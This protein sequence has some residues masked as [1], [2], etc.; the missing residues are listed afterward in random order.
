MNVRS[1]RY[2]S[3]IPRRDSGWSERT[4]HRGRCWLRPTG[5][6][7]A[8]AVAVAWP[9]EG[10]LGP[11]RRTE[12]GRGPFPTVRRC[13]TR[14]P[15]RASPSPP[16]ALRRS[17]N[18]SASM[19]SARARRQAATATCRASTVCS[20][21][22]AWRPAPTTEVDASGARQLLDDSPVESCELGG[23]LVRQQD[24]LLRAQAVLQRILRR[25]RPAFGRLRPARPRA[26]LAA[27]LNA[28]MA[29]LDG[30]ARDR[31]GTRHGIDPCLEGGWLEGWPR[32]SRQAA[33]RFCC[34]R[35][36]QSQGARASSLAG[37]S[38]GRPLRPPA[39]WPAPPRQCSR[40]GSG[41][42]HARPPHPPGR[43]RRLTSVP[44]RRPSRRPSRPTASRL[45]ALARGGLW[46]WAAG[47]AGA[48]PAAAG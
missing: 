19:R 27:R 3:A 46:A 34:R 47:P 31:A 32:P 38:P 18:S 30:R 12:R 6:K 24:E 44:S 2:N 16:A 11:H 21:P 13:P 15:S 26:V 5:L 9:P 42:A 20:A 29:D 23:I 28:S 22:R 45:F 25:A 17:S 40:P 35:P 43:S 4:D 39:P 48:V 36:C 1:A 41:A 7:R 10:G 37:R 14:R 8:G 33:G